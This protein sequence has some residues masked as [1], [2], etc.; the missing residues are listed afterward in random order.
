M[1]VPLNDYSNWND[2]YVYN[3][4]DVIYGAS[5]GDTRYFYSTIDS[6]LNA[7]PAATFSYTP[8][9]TSRT[10]NVMRTSF[11]QTGTAYFQPGSVVVVKNIEPDGSAN[12]TGVVLAGGAG[13]VDYLNP[14]LTTSN[15]VTAGTVSAPIH[16]YWT[17]GWY[18]IPGWSSQ[19]DHRQ[20]VINTQ[21]GEG[22]SQR[23]S[24]TINSNSL[25]WKLN[26]AE[27]TDREIAAMLNF[28]QNY[29]GVTPFNMPFPVGILYN[30]PNLK[31][32]ASNPQHTLTS[33]G[34][35]SVS[36]DIQQV[37]DIG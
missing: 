23:M 31:F 20:S 6:N 30:T 27:R 14:G 21:L 22:Y 8:T 11:T 34:L 29:G 33:F 37:F 19:V 4:W 16:P 15:A 35:N 10:D 17:T 1:A 12:Y 7:D 32:I 13:Y 25:N 24:P 18:W 2:S 5:A 36:V 26:F 3:K 28:I 9:Q